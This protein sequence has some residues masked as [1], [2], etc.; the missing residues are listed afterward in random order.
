LNISGIVEDWVFWVWNESKT[1][2][3]IEEQVA[4]NKVHPWIIISKE[5]LRCNY[6]YKEDSL[7]PVLNSD[8]PD[9][10][11]EMTRLNP[12]SSKNVIWRNRFICWQK[13][14]QG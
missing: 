6:K 1:A 3:E 14:K 2:K 7:L 11:I 12:S 4:G 8:D 13:H 10:S 5:R 9:C